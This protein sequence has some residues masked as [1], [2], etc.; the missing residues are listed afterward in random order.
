LSL[1]EA[2]IMRSRNPTAGVIERL[3]DRRLR[4]A[5]QPIVSIEDAS[6]VETNDGRAAI[7][8]V[9]RLSSPASR[10]VHVE[11]ATA[12]GTATASDGDYVASSGVIKFAPRERAKGITVL[13]NGDGKREPTETFV[14]NLVSAKHA[15]IGGGQGGVT[16]VD[17]D[18][19]PPPRVVEP[20]PNE[21]PSGFEEITDGYTDPFYYMDGGGGGWGW[22]GGVG[23]SAGEG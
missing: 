21:G 19:P 4:S 7:T 17:D 3:E 13:V 14:V 23:C 16:I 15:T 8:L 2:D 6:M 20:H 10:S 9:V 22:G 18:T 5:G 1:K 11:Y 12:D